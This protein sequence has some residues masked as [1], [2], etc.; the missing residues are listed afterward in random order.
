MSPKH[1]FGKS[2]KAK[3]HNAKS[4]KANTVKY[5]GGAAYQFPAPKDDEYVHSGS[6]LSDAESA[7]E[8]IGDTSPGTN[9]YIYAIYCM[10][11]IEYS[12]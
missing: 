8:A 12:L 3:S 9:I 4:E 10:I 1:K 6:S 5:H 7:E 11:L 2:T